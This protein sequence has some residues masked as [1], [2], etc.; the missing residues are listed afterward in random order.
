MEKIN[1]NKDQCIG[2]G[3]CVHTHPEYLIFDENGQAEPVDKEI[4]KE[5]KI[6]ILESIEA[7]PTEAISIIEE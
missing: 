7:C 6:S 3:M 4:K 1:I 5:D 2:C